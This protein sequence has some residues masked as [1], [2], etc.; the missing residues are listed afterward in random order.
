MAKNWQNKSLAQ[1]IP[2]AYGPVRGSSMARANGG[3]LPFIAQKQTGTI[4]RDKRGM[5]YSCF[6][7][8][9]DKSRRGRPQ[10]L[11]F[12]AALL[13]LRGTY[14][15]PH[16]LRHFQMSRKIILICRNTLSLKGEG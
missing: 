16:Y 5:L 10:A 4:R 8:F 14:Q 3:Y 12:C 7:L 6:G 1:H 15:G 9:E 13:Q 11:V 2:L